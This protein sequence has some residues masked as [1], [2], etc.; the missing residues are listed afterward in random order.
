[1]TKIETI[2]KLKNVIK[3]DRIMAELQSK[4][5]PEKN[6]LMKKDLGIENILKTMGNKE[7]SY[8]DGDLQFCYQQIGSSDQYRLLS[9][10]YPNTNEP[11]EDSVEL[12]RGKL[13]DMIEFKKKWILENS[14]Q[15]NQLFNPYIKYR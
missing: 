4:I 12:G 11:R 7:S 1:M 5:G 13:Q 8:K 2:E 6:I 10:E 14:N 9:N 15:N 3:K